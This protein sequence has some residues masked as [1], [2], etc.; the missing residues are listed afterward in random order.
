[1]C[2]RIRRTDAGITL[3][4]GVEKA[5]QRVEMA[6]GLADAM[7]GNGSRKYQ[8]CGLMAVMRTQTAGQSWFHDKMGRIPGNLG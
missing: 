6:A 3:V 2:K 4:V 8:A 7:E 5:G 1:M